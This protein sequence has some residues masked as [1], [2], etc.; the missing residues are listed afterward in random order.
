MELLKPIIYYSIFNYPLKKE[1]V[2][3]NAKY[4]N[5]VEFDNE[6]KIALDN[7]F[8]CEKENFY[9]LPG[10]SDIISKRELGNIN[11]KS[12]MKIAN[13][14]AKF[15][16]RY[17]PFVEAIGI[18]GSLSKGYF[19]EN[20]DVDF[21][22]ITK[23][24]RLWFCRT[25]LVL[26][27]KIFLFDSEKYFCMNYF[28]TDD[29]LKISEQNRFTATEITTLMPLYGKEIF[30]LFYNTNIWVKNYFPNKNADTTK[31]K[32]IQKTKFTSLFEQ[33]MDN[34]I[35][36][37]L[38]KICFKITYSH[39]K[40]KFGKSLGSHFELAFKSSNKVSKHHPQNFQNKV[41]SLLNVKYDL[42]NKAHN[43][44][45]EKEHV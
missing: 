36:T 5:I 32:T 14:K 20:S 37:F 3:L 8:I 22:I 43:L 26:Y 39:W 27:K 17:F 11:A 34:E 38:E 6:L 25:I 40:K 10:D 31:I 4:T 44:S 2:F 29:N 35:G 21:F 12:A 45:L 41:I 16:S 1:E 13:D 15:V 7:N 23:P 9:S 28:I 19:D 33:F 24:N 18:S 30:A 42:M